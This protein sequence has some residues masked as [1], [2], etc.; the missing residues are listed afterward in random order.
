[1]NR[2]LD[3]EMD[4]EEMRAFKQHLQSCSSCSKAFSDYR[5]ILGMQ[6]ARVSYETSRAGKD[7]FLKR[8]KRRKALPY[9]LVACCAAVMVGVVGIQSFQNFRQMNQRYE[10]IVNHGVQMLLHSAQ[11]A[12]STRF[13]PEAALNP[14]VEKGLEDSQKI[15]NLLNDGD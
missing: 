3:E 10:Q 8:L 11:D 4:L 5:K 15:L 7:K 13:S 1:M 12:S 14:E 2:F 6:K 9:Q